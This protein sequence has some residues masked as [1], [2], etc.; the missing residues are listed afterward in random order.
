LHPHIATAPNF[1]G[2]FEFFNL[3]IENFMTTIDAW[4]GLSA[5]KA[6][7]LNSIQVSLRAVVVYLVLI[8]Y[9]R[10]AKKRFLSQATAF[11]V[12]LVIIIGSISSRAISGTAP[13]FPSLAG[14]FV[15]IV[16]HW[17]VSYLTKD[18]KFL[19]YLTK[20]TA[21]TLICDGKVDRKAL[22][23]SHMSDDDLA[24]DL[25]QEGIESPSELKSARLERSGKLS[26]I[27]K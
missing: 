20:G 12:V 5:T 3:M 22:S 7:E 27:K 21:T 24:E 8:A 11:D 15:L 26:V 16:V 9:I 14:T 19:S 23:A 10:L 13:F 25:R 6:E 2:S 17:I 18:S 1:G 4:L